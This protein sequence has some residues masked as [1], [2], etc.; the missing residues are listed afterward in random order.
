M[1]LTTDT[2]A[3]PETAAMVPQ[4]VS[5]PTYQLASEFR[6]TAPVGV[7]ADGVRFASRCDVVLVSATPGSSEPGERVSMDV[8]GFVISPDGSA[9]PLSATAAPGLDFPDL[10]F[11]LTGSAYIRSTEPRRAHLDGSVVSIDGWVNFESGELEVVA[12]PM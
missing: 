1:T 9:M 6:E 10:D 11:R 2:S 8:S 12:R 3:Q 4:R 5:D 7:F